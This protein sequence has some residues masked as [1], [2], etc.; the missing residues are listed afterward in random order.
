[1]NRSD[2]QFTFDLPYYCAE[3]YGNQ[4]LLNYKSGQKWHSFSANDYKDICE[5]LAVGMLLNGIRSQE[6]V[7]TIFNNNSPY[8]NFLDMAIT[9][10]GAVHVPVYPTISDSD[11]L[12]ILNQ[13]E[14]RFVFVSDQFLYNR[15]SGLQANISTLSDIYTIDKLNNIQ[16]WEELYY[17]GVEMKEQ[18]KAEL[19]ERRKNITSQ[20]VCSIIYTSGTTGFPKGVMLSH[21]NLVSNFQTLA[22]LQPLDNGHR[23]MSFLPLCHVYERSANYQCQ[24]KGIKVYYC[25]SLKSIMH[26]FQEVKPHG[27]TVVPRIL[28]KIVKMVLLSGKKR[29]L[30]IRLFIQW[31]VGVGLRHKP[32]RKKT[33]IYK[34]WYKIAYL[35]VFRKVKHSMGG[36]L[37][38]IG[39]GGAPLNHKVQRFFWAAQMPVFEG[40]GLTEC[41]P[42]VSLNHNIKEKNYWI[43][44]VGSVL[45]GVEVRLSD[46]GEI[47]C[48]GPNVMKGYYKQEELTNETIVDGWMHTGDKGVFVREK[49]LQITGRKKEMFKTSYGK[50]IVPQ[51]IESKFAESLL[52]DHLVIVGEGKHCAAAIIAPDFSYIRS[53]YKGFEKLSNSKIVGSAELNALIRKEVAKVNKDLGKSEQIKKFLIV[54]DVWSTESGELSSTLKIRRNIIQK[55]YR[56]KIHNLFQNESI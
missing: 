45:P 33:F 47:L 46:E 1:M 2:I 27:T 25:E 24:I 55:K 40:Y 35:A 50:Y 26:N 11:Y 43:G 41:S 51:A 37:Q 5:S 14:A 6:N 4:A 19:N 16:H 32:Y 23:V 42:L 21:E 36:K 52:I 3:K 48:K 9:M 54:P 29:N 38:Y 44:T 13:T 20:T 10:I 53:Q 39:C 12:Y 49:Y 17:L 34:I 7:A 22:D 56:R 8:W 31:S 18:Y 15:I 30:I 28:E